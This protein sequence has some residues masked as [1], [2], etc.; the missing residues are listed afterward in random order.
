MRFLRLVVLLL[1]V[2][3]GPAVADGPRVTLGFGRLYTNDRIGDGQDRWRTGSWQL[4][5]VSGHGWDGQL[6][7]RFGDI[8]ELRFRTEII[9]PGVLYGPGSD[10]RPYAGALSYGMHTRWAA[11][12][13]EVSAGIDV[14]LTGPQTGLA[15][16]QD[17]FHERFSAP[18]LSDEVIAGQIGDGLYPSVTAEY[19]K[20]IRLGPAV[21]L[22]P[23]AEVQAGVE[24][25]ARLGAD[26]L[27]GPVAQHD[28][29]VRDQ[30]TGHLYRIT[31][32]G[33]DGLTFVA[34]VDWA[35]V[36]GSLW[37]PSDRGF[38]ALDERWRARAGL[39]LQF[40]EGSDVF[41]GLTWLSEEFEGQP[42]GQ[43]VGSLSVRF[44]F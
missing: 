39:H 27:I 35:H 15:A 7:A 5:V 42:E 30:T 25:I 26:V 36:E 41:A 9:A 21:Q 17:R 43:V 8:V 1:S 16:L 13:G 18:N 28:L 11:F 37:L 32:T 10:D 6:P 20:P 14:T 44:W 24:Q 19:G 23:F 31:Q 12:G 29:M 38:V 33:P 22:R 2:I 40:R 3:G 34:G 4:S